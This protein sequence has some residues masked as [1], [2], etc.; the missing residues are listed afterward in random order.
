MKK[1]NKVKYVTENGTFYIDYE[2]HGTISLDEDGIIDSAGL[3][4][5]IEKALNE[6][7][8]NKE[9]VNRRVEGIKTLLNEN[10]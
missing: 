5:D 4:K 10:E 3:F 1:T 7:V 2:N 6:Y 9:V 8:N